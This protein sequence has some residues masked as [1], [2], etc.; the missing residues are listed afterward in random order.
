MDWQATPTR[1]VAHGPHG[2]VYY[3]THPG[4][5]G[6]HA[7][8][9]AGAPKRIVRMESFDSREA[10][11]A[12][13]ASWAHQ[14]ASMMAQVSFLGDTPNPVSV[15]KGIPRTAPESDPVPPPAPHRNQLPMFPAEVSQ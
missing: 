10:A 3:V 13:C 4:Y 6:W 11:R 15:L 8:A 5:S 14:L 7:S 1:D 12:A 2:S 9:A